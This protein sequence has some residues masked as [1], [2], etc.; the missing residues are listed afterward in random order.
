MTTQNYPK[1]SPVQ[2]KVM[3][4]LGNRWTAYSGG[5][6]SITIN[7]SRMC[8]VD[9]MTSL[10]RHGLVEVGPDRSWNATEKGRQMARDLNLGSRY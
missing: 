1:L 6:A 4:F 5:G 9:T 7:G 8:N 3:S 10:A 2:L